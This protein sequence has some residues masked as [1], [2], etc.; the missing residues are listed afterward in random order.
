MFAVIKTGGKQYRVAKDDLIV[1]EKLEG[2]PGAKVD[3]AEVLMTGEGA[4]VKLGQALK[5]VSVAGEIVETRRGDKVIIFKK[6]RRNTYRRRRGHRQS[7]TVVKI[8]A[9]G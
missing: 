6:R 9:I 8:T 3:F 2:E 7:E 1:V 4:D 5:G